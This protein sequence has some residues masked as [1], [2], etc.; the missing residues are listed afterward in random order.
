MRH[1]RRCLAIYRARDESQRQTR[2]G[3][4][5]CDWVKSQP[6]KKTNLIK[7]TEERLWRLWRCLF[8]NFS[9]SG[10]GLLCV[11]VLFWLMSRLESWALV[12]HM[13]HGKKS[14]K[15]ASRANSGLKRIKNFQWKF[16]SIYSSLTSSNIWSTW[17]TF[18]LRRLIV[19]GII[20]PMDRHPDERLCCPTWKSKELCL[21]GQMWGGINL[22]CCSP[23]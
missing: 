14:K 21:R 8:N 19:Y 17:N 16:S 23:N 10:S 3:V 15:S 5:R 18:S 22:L 11:C 13:Q 7:S 9:F 12:D 1:I 20:V 4:E 2:S 6:E